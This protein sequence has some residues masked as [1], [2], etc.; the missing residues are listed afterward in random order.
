MKDEMLLDPTKN[1]EPTENCSVLVIGGGLVGSSAALFLAQKG[2]RVILIEKHAG[3]SPHPRAIGFTPRTLELFRSAGLAEDIPQIRGS[4]KGVRRIRVESLAGK[5]F[6]EQAWSPQTEE[7]TNLE[8]SPCGAS[9]IAQ[10][11][12]EPMIQKQAQ[13]LGADLRFSTELVRFEQTSDEVIAFVKDSEGNQYSI[14]AKYMIA[15]DGHRS[16]IRET[17][18]IG[19]KG[20]GYMNTGRSVLFKASLNEYL[21]KGFFQFTIDQPGFNVFLTTYNDGRWVLFYPDDAERT[22][23]K[24]ESDISRAIGRKDVPMEVV[25]T[26]RWE[27]SALIADSFS[28]GRIFIAGDAAHTLPPNRGGYGANTGI[29]DAHNLAWK[30][31]A[32]LSGQS[33]VDL[34]KT[35]EEERRPIAWLRYQQIFAKN[36]YKAYASEEDL[37]VPILDSRAIEFGQLYRSSSVSEVEDGLPPAL[38]PEQWAGQP[39]TRAPHFWIK[40]NGETISTLD[41]F[42]K[43]WVLLTESSDW[44]DLATE[45]SLQSPFRIEFVQFGLDALLTDANAFQKCFGV[46]SEGAV[47]VRPDGYIAWRS[48]DFPTNAAASLQD[49]LSKFARI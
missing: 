23:E 24:L 3:S 4:K 14:R 35:Y 46:E 45:F 32:V 13:E 26:G 6:E 39:G 41:L 44:K 37:S 31:E 47:L 2:V 49:A 38:R 15:A 43:S 11:R 28:S 5:W 10:D 33:K 19:R 48:L 25:T 27:I 20:K 1:A 34:L 7:E 36:D 29:E 16:P 12:L 8:Y 40:R 22:L 9:A 42:Q 17:L 21:E 18:K 30:L